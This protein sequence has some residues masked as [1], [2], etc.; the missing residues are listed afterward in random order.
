MSNE[1]D[2]PVS[3]IWDPSKQFALSPSK[4]RGM[5]PVSSPQKIRTLSPQKVRVLS[6]HDAFEMQSED[7]PRAVVYERSPMK[8]RRS[9]SNLPEEFT[10]A[11][12]KAPADALDLG[13]NMD[14]DMHIAVPEVPSTEMAWAGKHAP[15]LQDV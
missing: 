11:K 9:V 6:D 7:K 8:P 14:M 1:I 5:G 15:R 10:T 4:T 12:N 3:P 2:V 13:M